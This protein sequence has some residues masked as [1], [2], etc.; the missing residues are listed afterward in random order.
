MYT[1]QN[2]ILNTGFKTISL[3][4]TQSLTFKSV[5]MWKIISWIVVLLGILLVLIFAPDNVAVIIIAIVGIGVYI[6]NAHGLLEIKTTDDNYTLRDKGSDLMKL[7][8]EI[9]VLMKNGN[10]N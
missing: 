1:I 6:E 9:E 4:E 10:L 7:K 5:M 2:N 3:K 8:N